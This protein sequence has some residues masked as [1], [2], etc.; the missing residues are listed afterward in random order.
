M[1]VLFYDDS[2]HSSLMQESTRSLG[3]TLVRSAQVE[4]GK[5]GGECL[6]SGGGFRN[7]EKMV[8]GG[9]ADFEA[10]CS[11]LLGFCLQGFT[12]ILPTKFQAC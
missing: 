3:R 2:A 12:N 11:F 1:K 6:G 5:G 8:A 10:L 4:E 9:G 7:W